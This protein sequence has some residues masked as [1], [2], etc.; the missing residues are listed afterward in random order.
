MLIKNANRK[1]ES[2]QK[3]LQIG[4]DSQPF[5]IFF[6][7][8]Q[9][10][11]MLCSIWDLRS[12]TRD[13]TQAPYIWSRVLTREVLLFIYSRRWFSE[14]FNPPLYPHQIHTLEAT[15]TTSVFWHHPLDTCPGTSLM[16]PPSF[17]SWALP[18]QAQRSTAKRTET[19]TSYMWFP[20]AAVKSFPSKLKFSLGLILW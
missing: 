19:E 5:H 8:G 17:S 14:N 13:G 18:Q 6:L 11:T 9:G 20:W 3:N 15:V 7:G 4:E 10:S 1:G 2:L 16:W 12:L